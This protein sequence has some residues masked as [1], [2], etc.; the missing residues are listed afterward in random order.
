VTATRSRIVRVRDTAIGRRTVSALRAFDRYTL[1][2]LNPP[3]A[4]SS[5]QPTDLRRDRGP[6]P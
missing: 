3:P 5:R 6:R 4:L 2:A 1:T